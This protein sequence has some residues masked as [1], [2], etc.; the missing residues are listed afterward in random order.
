[1]NELEEGTRAQLDFKKLRK[2]GQTGEDVLP[3]V[4]QHADTGEVLYIGYANKRALDETLR[5][6]QAVLW[7]TSRN[8][9]WHKGATSGDF[10][11]L[12]DVRVNCEQN[13][14][15]YRVR[16]RSGVCHTKDAAGANRKRCYYRELVD[17]ET[18]R[19]VR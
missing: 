2:V 4:L 6:R 17:A 19:P 7:S 1:M 16:P 13:S 3:V 9:L 12:V 5:S 18:L 11:D 10:L 8:E 14:L 15:L